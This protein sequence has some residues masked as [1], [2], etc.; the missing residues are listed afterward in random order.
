MERNLE[1]KKDVVNLKIDQGLS[2]VN[3]ALSKLDIEWRVVITLRFGLNGESP[4]TV[5]EVAKILGTTEEAIISLEKDA[6][7]SLYTQ[8]KY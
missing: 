3:K 4:K 7:R 5:E 6:L 1:K 8:K 2:S